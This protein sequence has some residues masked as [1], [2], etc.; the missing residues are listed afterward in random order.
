MAHASPEELSRK[1]G[2]AGRQVEVGAR[3]VHYKDASRQYEVTG[4]AVNEADE[5]VLVLYKALYGEGFTFARPLESFAGNV[6]H[7]GR[8]T[9]RFVRA[10]E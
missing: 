2:E 7:D 9:A 10:H 8:A 6:E 1:L 5:A 4:F 3:Y